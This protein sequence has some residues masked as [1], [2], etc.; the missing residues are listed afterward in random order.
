M[1]EQAVQPGMNLLMK[2]IL[3]QA[4]GIIFLFVCPHSLVRIRFFM[5]PGTDGHRWEEFAPQGDLRRAAVQFP[6][7]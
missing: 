5:S 7:P 1:L 2:E 4:N 3:G 6:K